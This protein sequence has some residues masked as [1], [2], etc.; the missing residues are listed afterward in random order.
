MQTDKPRHIAIIMDG[1]GRW[2]T[3]QGKTRAFGHEQGAR[4]AAEA[5]RLGQER[6]IEQLTLY[7][8]SFANYRRPQ[9]EVDHLMSLCG[10]FAEDHRDEFVER[11]IRLT[12]IGEL[13]D[14]PSAARRAIEN[15]IAATAKGTAMTL[16]LAI[17]YGARNDLVG[18]IR[19]LTARAYAGLLLPEEVDE[20]T[21][22]SFMTAGSLR[23]PDL[24]IRTG[25]ERRLS[26]FLLF[27]SAYAE[28]FF[29]DHMWPD[30]NAELLDQ[31]IS[32]YAR[33]DRRYGQ[34]G[35]QLANSA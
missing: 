18:A 4:V 10:R 27:E 5:F 28:L 34:I 21:I 22:R 32:A 12:V 14:L 11:G 8:F 23:D 17:G 24:V 6:G 2:A 7:A 20:T 19:A 33:R 15:T 29:S 30:F 35:E 25:G 13:E 9:A 31:A 16:C 3:A 1:N 26:D